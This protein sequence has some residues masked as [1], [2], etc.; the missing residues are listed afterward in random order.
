MNPPLLCLS[1]RS[2]TLESSPA[3]RSTSL[4]NHFLRCVKSS[5]NKQALAFLQR[6]WKVFTVNIALLVCRNF[7][8][9]DDVD[10]SH[11]GLY[12][13]SRNDSDRARGLRSILL[14]VGVDACCLRWVLALIAKGESE[15][16]CMQPTAFWLLPAQPRCSILSWASLVRRHSQQACWWAALAGDKRLV[17]ERLFPQSGH[18]CWRDPKTAALPQPAS[19]SSCSATSKFNLP[20]VILF[21]QRG[22]PIATIGRPDGAGP[23]R[24]RTDGAPY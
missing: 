22:G 6:W 18:S 13:I 5:R 20:I 19:W 10:G 14:E 11:N 17:S 23:M 7:E 15:G 24:R 2:A 21:R 1:S 16:C 12:G 8:S 9:R 4:W 3:S